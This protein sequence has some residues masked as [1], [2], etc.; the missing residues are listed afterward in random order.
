MVLRVPL[1]EFQQGLSDF[2][3]CG[4]WAV[5]FDFG[6]KGVFFGLFSLRHSRLLDGTGSELQRFKS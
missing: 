6:V 2:P 4:L 5:R 3:V 1:P